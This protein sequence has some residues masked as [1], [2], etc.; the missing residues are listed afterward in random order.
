M[1]APPVNNSLLATRKS[2]N[3]RLSLIKGVD[4]VLPPFDCATLCCPFCGVILTAIPDL[5]SLL[6]LP[7]TVP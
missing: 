7:A 6:K 5:G 2:P 4:K 3:S 1:H